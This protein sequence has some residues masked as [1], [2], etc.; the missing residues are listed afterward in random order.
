M[1]TYIVNF[2]NNSALKLVETED[3]VKSSCGASYPKSINEKGAINRVMK[4]AGLEMG[5]RWTGWVEL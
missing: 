3:Y 5:T 4:W 2:A 1:K